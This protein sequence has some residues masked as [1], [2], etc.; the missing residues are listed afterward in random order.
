ML[1]QSTDKILLRMSLHLGLSEAREG[2][3]SCTFIPG[4]SDGSVC[5]LTKDS[6]CCED[7]EGKEKNMLERITVNIPFEFQ[8][9][10]NKRRKDL[11]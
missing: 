5:H 8:I 6:G 11:V 7:Q 1:L 4:S 9:Q 3:F 10:Q 2:I